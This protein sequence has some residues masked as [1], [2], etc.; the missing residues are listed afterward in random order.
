MI[1]ALASIATL[2]PILVL[3]SRAGTEMLRPMAF[4]VI[5]GLVTSTALTAFA[6]PILYFRYRPEPGTRTVDD[7]VDLARTSFVML[8]PEETGS[9]FAAAV[10]SPEQ[11]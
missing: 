4:V 10:E 11:A 7:D 2:I 9:G 6:L 1:T 5:G 3:G 8:E